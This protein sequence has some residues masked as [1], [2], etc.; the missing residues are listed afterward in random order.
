MQFVSKLVSITIADHQTE[1]KRDYEAWTSEFPV[2]ESV[3]LFCK[4]YG[5]ITI[6]KRDLPF[7][8]DLMKQHL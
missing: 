1:E 7:V 3:I 2:K 6:P 8:L 4:G 5:E